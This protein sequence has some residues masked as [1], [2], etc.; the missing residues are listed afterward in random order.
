MT[1]GYGASCLLGS[2]TNEQQT[3]LETALAKPHTHR[4]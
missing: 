1:Y 3:W 2:S 4:F